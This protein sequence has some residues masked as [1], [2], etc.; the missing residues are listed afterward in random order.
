MSAATVSAARSMTSRVRY[1]TAQMP[2]TR[3]RPALAEVNAWETD[4]STSL[5]HRARGYRREH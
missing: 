1:P 2:V 5:T 4:G 3:L